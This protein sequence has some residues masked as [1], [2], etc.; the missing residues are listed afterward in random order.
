MVSIIIPTLNEQN[1]I[2]N[3]IK[4]FDN[5]KKNIILKLLYLIQKVLIAQLKY[6]K[7]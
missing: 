1:N 6:Q 3:T 2:L 4:Q 5:Y 7:K